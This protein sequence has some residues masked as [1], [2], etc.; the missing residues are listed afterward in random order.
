MAWWRRH[1][2]DLEER[3]VFTDTAA[4]EAHIR[5]AALADL[6]LDTDIYGA[7]STGAPA[8][9][10]GAEN[11]QAEKRNTKPHVLNPWPH[12]RSPVPGTRNPEPYLPDAA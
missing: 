8:P 11:A 4:K 9:I 3:L 2:P 10:L 5:R 6:F 12:I 1:A 7:H